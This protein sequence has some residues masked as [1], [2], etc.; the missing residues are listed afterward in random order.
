MFNRKI[1]VLMIALVAFVL[2][3]KKGVAD[4]TPQQNS[5]QLKALSAELE[6]RLLSIP[7]S[8]NPLLDTTGAN[9]V[10]GQSGSVWIMPT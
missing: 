9:C 7:T 8:V 1:V 5:A 2:P 3:V 10:V 4:P 6:A